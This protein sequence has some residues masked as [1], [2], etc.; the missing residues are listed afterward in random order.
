M[1]VKCPVCGYRF[2]ESARSSCATCPVGPKCNMICCP[3]CHYSWVES[4]SWVSSLL[5]FAKKGFRFGRS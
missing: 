3:N 2:D 4:S 5:E 1:A